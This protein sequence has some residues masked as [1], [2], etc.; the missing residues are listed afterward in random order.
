MHFPGVILMHPS[1]GILILGFGYGNPD[2]WIT[3]T[4][5][6]NCMP[7]TQSL[8]AWKQP[9]ADVLQSSSPNTWWGALPFLS[10][11]LPQ[12]CLILPVPPR[13]W[14]ATQWRSFPLLV[15]SRD[16]SEL[17]TQLLAAQPHCYH[18][19]HWDRE[20]ILPHGWPKSGRTMP[21][22]MCC[23]HQGEK[24]NPP[25]WHRGFTETTLVRSLR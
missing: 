18:G 1:S 11:Q 13:G 23:N 17:C 24:R 16:R 2:G 6:V 19:T 15:C 8:P 4:L 9:L 7:V 20:E 21:P 10:L 5:L 12:A 25:T 22:G 14:E 3:V